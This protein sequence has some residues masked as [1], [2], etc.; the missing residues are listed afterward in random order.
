MSQKVLGPNQRILY[1]R[2]PSSSKQDLCK[3][4]ILSASTKFGDLR[5]E[6]VASYPQIFSDQKRPNSEVKAQA[7][8]EQT[9]AKLEWVGALT[10]QDLAYRVS[11]WLRDLPQFQK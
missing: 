7:L 9:D 6:A 1:G 4:E 5:V 8:A 3:I 11:T 10:G 2:V